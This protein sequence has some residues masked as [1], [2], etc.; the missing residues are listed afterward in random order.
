MILYRTWHFDLDK[1][2]DCEFDIYNMLRYYK[3]SSLGISRTSFR[4]LYCRN[5]RYTLVF[6][7][8]VK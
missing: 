7:I 4:D 5:D 1:G 3:S 2:V 8:I 6:E